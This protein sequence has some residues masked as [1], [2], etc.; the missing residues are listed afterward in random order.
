LAGKWE[1]PATLTVH[2]IA[3]IVD[4]YVVTSSVNPDRGPYDITEQHWDGSTLTWTFYVAAND[5][6]VTIETISVD[7]DT[8]NFDWSQTTG[9]SGTET[10]TRVQ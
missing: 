6:Y 1:D 10:F 8:L 9:E 4:S 5:V 3:W 7:G 2:T